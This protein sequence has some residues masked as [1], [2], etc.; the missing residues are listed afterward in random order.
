MALDASASLDLVA[1]APR[2]RG[3]IQARAATA[4]ERLRRWVELESPSDDKA[5]LDFCGRAIADDFTAAHARLAIHPQTQ[6]GDHL[7]LTLAPGREKGPGLL[8]LGHFDTVY[9]LG[10]LAAMPFCAAGGRIQGPGVLDMK[11]GISVVYEAWVA[12]RH[13]GLEA[14]RPVT[15]LLVSDEETGSATA[16][17][18]IERLAR[19]AAAVLVLEPGAGAEGRLKTARK[20][21]AHFSVRAEGIA[22]HAGVDFEQGASA[23]LEL[24][25]QTVVWAGL[26][27]LERGVTVNPGVLRGGTRSNVVAASAELELDVRAWRDQDLREVVARIQSSRPHDP[28]VKLA[29]SGGIN[30]P[31]MEPTPAAAALFERACG[32]GRALGLAL[33]AAATGGG[34][35]GN[36]T[37]ALGV[38]TLD[39]LGPA[40]GG[41]HSPG[42]Y[43]TA[44]SLVSRAALLAL[45]LLA[46]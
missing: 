21:I 4:L 39:G 27:D 31:P 36:F 5:A 32:I 11:G 17:P 28:R 29:V 35:D 6:A 7:E 26:T 46:L 8:L 12:L 30:R 14:R 22:A 25:R 41:A 13:F 42:E 3:V 33:A 44:D 34:S 24:A 16:R 43:C 9:P 37:A 15:L 1:L 40:G 23:L 10:T 38:P 2:L 19:D 20:G 45:L 18:L